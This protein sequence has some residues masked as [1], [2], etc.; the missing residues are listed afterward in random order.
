MSLQKTVCE[1]SKFRSSIP[2]EIMDNEELNKMIKVLPANYNFEIHKCIWQIQKNNYQKV[3]LQFPEGLLMYSCFISDILEMFTAS[4]VLIMGD[5]TYGACC[6]DDFTAKALGCDFLIHYGHSCLIPVN[7]T[8]IKAMYVFVDISF[9]LSHLTQVVR[10][11]F[12]KNKKFAILGTIQFASSIPAIREA[13]CDYDIF[14]PQAKPLSPGEVLGCTAPKLPS[15]INF[16]IY[17]GDGRFHLEAIMIANSS[18][19]AYR[20]DPYSKV[21][22]LEYYDI[23]QMH[24][25]RKSS[26][27]TA[28]KS[29]KIGL[30]LGTLGRQGSPKILE[31]LKSKL[32]AKNIDF[33][34][35]LISEITP[36]KLS[37]FTDIDA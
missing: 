31:S 18:I 29:K 3:A 26:I 20:Y 24:S 16:F 13:L 23:E 32:I 30:I 25:L 35:F 36:A 33:C 2:P 9:D 15:D 8:L 34:V 6:V 17:L 1:P 28:R 5:V 4:K 11:N 7:E 19:P 37:L 10:A 27:E 12:D 21:M 14:V 22:S